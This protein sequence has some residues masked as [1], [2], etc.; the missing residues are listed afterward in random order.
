MECLS[1]DL[2]GVRKVDTSITCTVKKK[3]L[4]RKGEGRGVRGKIS[5][6]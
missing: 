1:R 6:K 2:S 3:N 4:T 5:Y